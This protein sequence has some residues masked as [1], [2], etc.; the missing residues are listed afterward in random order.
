MWVGL[1]LFCEE[2]GRMVDLLFIFIASVR[3]DKFR[4]MGMRTNATR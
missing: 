3:K 2:K 1:M 4:F